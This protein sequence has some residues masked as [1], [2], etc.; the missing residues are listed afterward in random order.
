MVIDARKHLPPNT[1]EADV[2]I[3][4]AGPAGLTLAHELARKGVSVCLLESGGATAGSSGRGLN[5]G[6]VYSP[7]GYRRETL[8]EGRSRQ[9]GGSAALWNHLWRGH[10]GR[11][12]RYLP[13][14]PI[15]FERRDWVPESGWPFSREEMQPFYER[16]GRICGIADADAPDRPGDGTTAPPWAT[17]SVESF[18][19]R[20][21]KSTPFLHE[22]P[23]T[24]RRDPRTGVILHATLKTLRLNA[25]GE[26]IESAEVTAEGRRDF[27]VR[28]R[29]FVLAAGGLENARL[30]LLH[31]AVRRGGLGNAHDMVGRCF[32]DHPAVTLGQ[33]R[34]FSDALFEDAAFYD[35]RF[36]NGR[37]VMGCL[38][39]RPEVMRRERMLN[40]S[41]AVSPRLRDVRSNLAPVAGQLF[42][43]GPRFLWERGFGRAAG[44]LPPGTSADGG[45]S[46]WRR[47]LD[48]YYSECFCGW[49]ETRRKR[50][51]F[52]DFRVRCLVEQSADRSNRVTLDAAVDAFGQR[53]IRLT[54][55]WNEPEL[56]TLRKAQEIFGAELPAAGIGEFTPTPP[57]SDGMPPEFFSTHHFMGTTRMHVDPSQGVVDADSR[58][59][60]MGNLFVAGSS[61]FPTSG[62]ANPTLTIVA[63][64]VRLA[65]HLREKLRET[66]VIQEPQLLPATPSRSLSAPRPP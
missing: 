56:R 16:A 18:T 51:R 7:H 23:A 60:G 34:P 31:D 27:R 37:A 15:D 6:E 9:L 53:K 5:G 21:G 62:F 22:L 8:T 3:V 17:P 57:G 10:A 4:G 42:T 33:L 54:W 44:A 55:R 59:H 45:A 61:I 48:G 36:V 39:I 49:S 20:F 40:L 64:A 29:I 11:W 28:A 38:H 50:R 30:L 25:S 47:L 19:A 41:A 46:T 63:L 32:M 14:D 58:V 2:C 12:I 65:D 1:P 26:A 43:K 24:L 35:Q 52:S 13:L 66:P